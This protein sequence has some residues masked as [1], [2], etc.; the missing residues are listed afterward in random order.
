M[1]I[2]KEKIMQIIFFGVGLVVAVVI[3]QVFV[4]RKMPKQ[5]SFKDIMDEIINEPFDKA[6]NSEENQDGGDDNPE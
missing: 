4:V 3:F 5:E 2:N 1:I 6:E